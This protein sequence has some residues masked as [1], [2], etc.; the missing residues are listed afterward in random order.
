MS[1]DAMDGPSLIDTAAVNELLKRARY[2]VIEDQATLPQGE[3]SEEAQLITELADA[4]E[5]SEKERIDW[6][7]KFRAAWA[8]VRE[9]EQEEAETCPDGLCYAEYIEQLQQTVA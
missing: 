7:L 4:F 6:M 8:A 2:W 5:R 3:M 1:S 9:T